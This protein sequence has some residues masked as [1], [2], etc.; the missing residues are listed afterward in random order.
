MEGSKYQVTKI[1]TPKLQPNSTVFTCTNCKA[2]LTSYLT[3]T[4]TCY[5]VDTPT[6]TTYSLV[7]NLK[8][9]YNTTRAYELLFTVGCPS[10]PVR[11]YNNC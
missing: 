1:L 4:G 10:G 5:K 9:S 11:Y 6:S 2:T 3:C 7:A 8:N